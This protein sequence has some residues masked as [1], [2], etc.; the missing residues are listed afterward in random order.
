MVS[1]SYNS[2]DPNFTGSIR[3]E[4]NYSRVA[5]GYHVMS[6]WSRSVISHGLMGDE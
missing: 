6:R 3:F 5:E 2:L 1:N 4:V